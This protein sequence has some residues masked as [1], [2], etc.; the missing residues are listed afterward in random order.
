MVLGAFGVLGVDDQWKCMDLA[1]GYMG[2]MMYTGTRNEL[3][4]T[5]RFNDTAM[6]HWQGT[7]E[8]RTCAHALP[9]QPRTS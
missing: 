1:Y 6:R 5:W 8:G 4:V 9:G 3:F 7:A 2:G